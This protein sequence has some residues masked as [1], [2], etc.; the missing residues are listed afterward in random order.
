[1]VVHESRT[2]AGTRG[3]TNHEHTR[4]RGSNLLHPRARAQRAA[5]LRRDRDVVHDRNNGIELEP[6]AAVEL[7]SDGRGPWRRL[8]RARRRAVVVPAPAHARAY[9]P[10]RQL[11]PTAESKKRHQSSGRRS[12]TMQ[13][14][15]QSRACWYPVKRARG[16]GA[17]QCTVAAP[18][19]HRQCRCGP[20][21]GSRAQRPPP[22]PRQATHNSTLHVSCR[23]SRASRD[24]DSSN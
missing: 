5:A 6:I 19:A 12:Y 14:G 4:A 24:V 13:T 11:Q 9:A 18:R 22:P 10:P 8:R 20:A 3:Q 23:W 17:S 7:H 2:H 21:G 16:L 15:P 1:M